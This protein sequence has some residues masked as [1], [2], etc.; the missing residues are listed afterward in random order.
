MS[1]KQR[2]NMYDADGTVVTHGDSQLYPSNL[3]DVSEDHEARIMASIIGGGAGS[4]GVFT[5]DVYGTLGGKERTQ[6]IGSFNMT[7]NGVTEVIHDDIFN[8]KGLQSIRVR[9]SYG[10]A[11]AN[12][13]TAAVQIGIP[14]VDLKH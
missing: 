5:V 11:P 8:I 12:N 6:P 2:K 13:V 4:V 9:L 1:L 7:A 10:G 14:H 3:I